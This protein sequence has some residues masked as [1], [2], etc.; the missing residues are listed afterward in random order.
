MKNFK[1]ALCALLAVIMLVTA[2]PMSVSAATDSLDLYYTTSS[3]VSSIKNIS[4]CKITLDAGYDCAFIL[5]S[6]ST[7]TATFPVSGYANGLD[8]AVITYRVP[9]ANGAGA[10]KGSIEFKSGNNTVVSESIYWVRGYRFYSTIIDVAA[11]SSCDSVVI[12]FFSNSGVGDSARLYSISFCATAEEASAKATANETAANG[13][14]VNKYTE[15]QLGSKSYV[16]EDYMLPY[17]DTDI[18]YNENVYPLCNKDGS[19]DDIELMYDVDRI[20]SVKNYEL[21]EEYREGIDYEIVDGKLRILTSGNIPTVSYDRHYFTYNASGT[22]KM[23]NPIGNRTYVRFEE[24]FNIPKSQL[25]I[26][27]THT[28]SWTGYI[29]EN[30]GDQLPRTKAKLEN[31]ESLNIVLFGDSITNGGNSSG[32]IG[33]QP[34]AEEWTQ[35]F[36]AELRKTFPSS[37]I[38][39]TNTSISGGAWETAAQ[40]VYNAIV[41]YSPDLLV[42]ALGVNDYQFKYSASTV[43]GQV[44]YV[45]GVVKEECPHTE[46]IIVA[47]MLS[48]P[49][50]FDPALLHQ[51]VEGYYQRAEW[52]GDA[53]IADVT[54]V[55]EYLLERKFYTDMS[56]NNL[57][58]LN[59]FLA[60]TYAHTMLKTIMPK[61]ASYNFKT[62]SKSRLDYITNKSLYFEAEQTQITSLID[63]AKSAIDKATTTEQI[64]KIYTDT[65]AQIC[66]LP[67]KFD[68][69]CAN[70]DFENII[71]DSELKTNLLTGPHY[72]TSVFNAGEPAAEI[73]IANGSDPYIYLTYSDR[74]PTNA[75]DNKYV[76]FTYKVPYSNSASSD[77][78]QLY[79]C[80]GNSYAPSSAASKTFSPIKDG[81]YHSVVLDLSSASWWN[82]IIHQIRIDPFTTCSAYDKMYVYSVSL[83]ET[84]EEAYKL[85]SYNEENANHTYQPPSHTVTFTSENCVD[86]TSAPV[87]LRIAG[88]SDGN[89]VLNGK[90]SI[91]FKKFNAGLLEMD[92]DIFDM[93]RDGKV[94]PMDSLLLKRVIAGSIEPITFEAAGVATDAGFDADEHAL[95]VSDTAGKYLYLSDEHELDDPSYAVVVYKVVSGSSAMNVYAGNKVDASIKKTAPI[96]TNGSYSYFIISLPSDFEGNGITLDVTGYDIYIDS[97]GLFEESSNIQSFFKGREAERYMMSSENIEITFTD[98]NMAKLS[99]ENHTVYSNTDPANVLKLTVAEN[100]ID[101]YI[102]LDVTELGFSADEYKYIVYS[103]MLPTSTSNYIEK[104]QLFFCSGGA[105]VPAEASSMKFDLQK[106]GNYVNEIFDMTD[107]SYWSGDAAGIRLDYFC[108]AQLDD[109]C[110]IRCITFCK[111]LADAERY[112]SMLQ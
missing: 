31:G 36:A 12:N 37:S 65:K 81:S 29:P 90:D 108:N 9:K 110:Y 88:D 69:V 15:T 18:I 101:P 50:C 8:Y 79:F 41:P 94:N 74:Y 58:H 71:F 26:T 78:T 98:E 49:E 23:I 27:Y 83:A 62:Q 52:Y 56:A 67:K 104:G 2:F 93:N 77:N 4:N 17:W 14:I 91:T 102:Y 112:I 20:V 54:Q 82:G 51:Y 1:H 35:M 53:V 85:A 13:P 70:T 100:R 10:S 42:L 95:R 11:L 73:T 33:M 34:Y 7:P 80:A 22:Y 89:S 39:V 57:C 84:E 111:T 97:F 25:A 63:S 44:D 40:N 43:L 32:N 72:V 75:D 5:A 87:T 60:R 38:S 105:P 55:H 107:A 68:V 61:N 30:K 48:N 92:G 24:G 86:F 3:S 106:T 16:Q 45:L 46:V 64:R 21:T 66:V 59:D 103:Y 6:G 96:L 19:I 47:P 99:N 28:D 109:T 76:V